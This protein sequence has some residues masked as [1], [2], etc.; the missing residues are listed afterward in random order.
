MYLP[1]LGFFNTED[2]EGE[3]DR[4]GIIKKLW[5]FKSFK[6]RLLPNFKN[7]SC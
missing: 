7:L 2:L 1:F 4:L 6:F 3:E 5:G